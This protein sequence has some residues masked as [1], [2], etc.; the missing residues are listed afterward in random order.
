MITEQY[1]SFETAKMLEEAGFD[2]PCKR[3]FLKDGCPG[4]TEEEENH[5]DVTCNSYS[6][7]SQS[8]VARWL[9][10]VHKLHICVDVNA[11]GWY[12]GIYKTD[13]GTYISGG[14]Q[15][16]PNDGGCW[17]SYEEALEAGFQK[18][19]RLIIKTKGK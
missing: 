2:V 1:V 5:N 19:L 4:I 15:C 17:D 14:C 18:A 11:S 3:L 13:S 12:Y 7:P 8:L 16:G 9:R 6:R 10:E